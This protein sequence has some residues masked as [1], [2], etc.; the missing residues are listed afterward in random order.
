MTAAP[1]YGQVWSNPAKRLSELL[2]ERGANCDT[3]R[4]V[5][6]LGYFSQ[7][8]AYVDPAFVSRVI[9]W[10][11]DLLSARFGKSLERIPADLKELPI[12][13]APTL[14]TRFDRQLTPD[15]LR[16]IWYAGHIEETLRW[17]RRQPLKS[18]L[19]IGSGYG[20]LAR[21]FKSLHP[22]CTLWLLDL[23]ESLEIARIYLQAHLPDARII[24]A[25]DDADL[26]DIDNA[27]FV[28]VPTER[29]ALL[30][31]RQFD[32]AVNIWSF[33]EMP[34]AF[35]GKWFDLIQRRA[36]VDSLFTL[37]AFMAPVTHLS[38]D[39]I[40]Q[41]DWLFQ[42]DDGWDI[43]SFEVDP[44]IHRCPDIRNFYCGVAIAAERTRDETRL[45][46]LKQTAHA[47]AVEVNS[48]D[49]ARLLAGGGAAHPATPT[50]IGDSTPGHKSSASMSIAELLSNTEYVGHFDI[51]GLPVDPLFRLWN[52]FRLNGTVASGELLVAYLAMVSKTDLKRRCTKEELQLLLRLPHGRLHVEYE[53]LI[54]TPEPGL[55]H[56][57]TTYTIQE[58]CDHALTCREEGNLQQAEE[59]FIKV[60]SASPHHG[61]AWY[62]LAL[63]AEANGSLLKAAVRA[64]HACHLAPDYEH[65]KVL[66][67][68]LWS[69]CKESTLFARSCCR[70]TADHRVRGTRRLLPVVNVLFVGES[71]ARG[72]TAGGL[73]VL[74]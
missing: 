71:S 25:A 22:Q 62:Y 23:T 4:S 45:R 48:Q 34:N 37:N 40:N 35:V 49:W 44:A 26:T 29:A 15:L 20:C 36:T 39:R 56:S 52:D 17:G 7:Y 53:D 46:S 42:L 69:Q 73:G 68:R 54:K 9:D 59:M 16:N 1:P 14:A 31:A 60:A 72:G 43:R 24:V 8:T 41:G 2:H 12:V 38:R 5:L 61:D 47:E 65:Y 55:E 11:I 6:E 63:I 64:R 58:A 70:P 51:G 57:G 21:V 3:L 32:L 27:D 33:G 13:P 67:E 28:L 10:Q 50:A 74:C 18:V 66:Y 19:E 30:A